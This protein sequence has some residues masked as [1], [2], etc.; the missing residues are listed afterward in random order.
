MVGIGIYY[1]VNL[2]NTSFLKM[3][4]WVVIYKCKLKNV[5]IYDKVTGTNDNPEAIITSNTG[6]RP[7]ELILSSF[8]WLLLHKHKFVFKTSV[9]ENL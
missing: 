7:K 6:I 9:F 1:S 8:W 5:R 4:C 2:Y 3:T